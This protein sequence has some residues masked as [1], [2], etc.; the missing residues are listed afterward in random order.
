MS[1]ALNP[2]AGS[3]SADELRE[4]EIEEAWSEVARQV[5]LEGELAFDDHEEEADNKALDD[6]DDERF[7]ND[8]Y[9]DEGPAA[10]DRDTIEEDSAQE[11]AVEEIPYERVVSISNA[12][13]QAGLKD[14]GR[15]STRKASRAAREKP[16]TK[17]VLEFPRGVVIGETCPIFG[18]PNAHSPSTDHRKRVPLTRASG[19]LAYVRPSKP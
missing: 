16:H 11:D 18:V 7:L 6:A 9:W 15:V 14:Y 2:F 12:L 13:M 4:L 19:E 1:E 10:D 17:I 5:R 3:M 8:L